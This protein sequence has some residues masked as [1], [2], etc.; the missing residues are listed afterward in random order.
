M[1]DNRLDGAILA[2]GVTTFDDDKDTLAALNHTALQLHELDLQ[3]DQQR[4]IPMAAQMFRKRWPVLHGVFLLDASGFSH[5]ERHSHGL[6]NSATLP[7]GDRRIR[8]M[9]RG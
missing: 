7:E 8:G 4:V 5:L 2:G 9:A 3:T 1:F 6:V